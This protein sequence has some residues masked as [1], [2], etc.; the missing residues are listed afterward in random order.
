MANRLCLTAAALALLACAP[1]AA[2]KDGDGGREARVAG[3][4]TR[5]ASSELRVRLQ[6]GAIRVEFV[7]NP[8]STRGQWRLV[9]VYQR[10]V[11]RRGRNP[12]SA[13]RGGGR[14]R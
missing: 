2:A 12:S 3:T 11:G 8:R 6:D 14:P 13:S 7:V 10:R 5:G 4:C 1:Q 9:L